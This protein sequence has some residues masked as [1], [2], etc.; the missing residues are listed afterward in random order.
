MEPRYILQSPMSFVQFEAMCIHHGFR[1]WHGKEHIGDSV[2]SFA[3][4]VGDH[5][6]YKCDNVHMWSRARGAA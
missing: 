6:E 2:I 5:S 3:Y 4:A 1:F